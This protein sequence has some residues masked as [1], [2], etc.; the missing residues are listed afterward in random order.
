MMGIV[1]V[2]SEMQREGQPN[3]ENVREKDLRKP[4][5]GKRNGALEDANE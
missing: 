4:G 5:S 1:Q 2:K 3:P